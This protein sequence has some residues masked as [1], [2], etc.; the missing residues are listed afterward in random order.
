MYM[1]RYTLAAFILIALV[2][3]FVSNYVAGGSTTIA[4]D[5]FGIPLPSFSVAF[6]VTVP[7]FILYLASV[8]H[9][10]FYSFLDNLKHRKY[11]KDYEKI[12]DAMVDA[13]LGKAERNHSFKT[14]RYQLLGQ[15]IDNT[16][17]FQNNALVTDNVKLNKVHD[18]IEDIKNGKV[19]DLKAYSLDPENPILTQNNRNR[20][21][22]GEITAE[23]ILTHSSRYGKELCKEAYSDFVAT[24]PLYAIEQ[25]KQF[26]TKETLFKVLSRVNA[27]ENTLEISN[28]ILIS[29]FKDLDLDKKDYMEIATTISKS[30]IPEQRMKLFETISSKNEDA[31]DAYLYTLFD[32]EMNQ[33]AVEILN[34]SLSD[35]YLNFKAYYALK[36]CNKTYDINLFI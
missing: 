12:I 23:D 30:M 33:L 5:L 31:M 1:K 2:W 16:T 20:Y 7:L 6:W 32:L 26:L 14:D 29:L 25:Y 28:E 27:S 21:K 34:I 17:F 24:S 22:S 13:Y 4:I 18:L 15:F 36:E 19:V 35:E 9:F 10:T 8:I 3:L 11:E